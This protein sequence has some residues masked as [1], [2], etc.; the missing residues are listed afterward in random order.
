VGQATISD[1]LNKGHVPRADTL[2]RLADLFG[3]P[4]EEVLRLAGYLPAKPAGDAPISV[5]D[6]YLV[7]ELLELFDQV[8]D[9]W[10]PEAL[11]HLRVLVRL[12]SQPPM[13]I[14][15]EG[16]PQTGET[17]EEEDQKAGSQAA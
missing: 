8:P 4:R 17:E 16:E 5:K 12:A 7:A 9:G 2:F 3:V 15:G 6:G 10:K 1:I 13:R 11:A 14:I